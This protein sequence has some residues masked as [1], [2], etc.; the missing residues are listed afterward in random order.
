MPHRWPVALLGALAAV[1]FVEA[2]LARSGLAVDP[3]GLEWRYADKAARGRAR[4][5]PILGLALADRDAAALAALCLGRLV[6]SVGGRRAIRSRLVGPQT[7][8]KPTPPWFAGGRSTLDR[9]LYPADW[10]CLP[11]RRAA[12]ERL[13]NRAAAAGVAVHWLM[14]P[15]DPE[16]T[17]RRAA[18][19]VEARYTEIALGLMAEHPGLRVVDGRRLA[20]RASMRADPVHLNRLGSEAFTARVADALADP[21][22]P[23]WA[24]LGTGALPTGAGSAIHDKR[25]SLGPLS[26][27]P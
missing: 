4:S 9:M 12:V 22:A 14:P 10:R 26:A 1:A 8:V 13:L 7:P 5:A 15:F 16:T 21:D 6:P 27:G 25:R 20:L 2:G 23:R 11:A 19:G 24:D 3:V 17:A 18:L